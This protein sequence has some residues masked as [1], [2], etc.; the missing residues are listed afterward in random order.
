MEADKQDRFTLLA[1]GV[2]LAL[3]SCSAVWFFYSHRYLLYYGDA[4]AHL[5]IARRVVDSQT[6]GYLQLGSPWLPLPHVLM[7]PFV[8]NDWLW[9]SGLAGAIPSAACFT[10]AGLFLFAAARR[11]FRCTAAAAT[12]TAL[13]ALNPNLLYLQSIPMSESIFFACLMALLYFTVRF[14]QTQG[15]GAV[16]GAGAAACAATLS[17]YDGWVLL[18]FA[19]LFFLIAARG[20]RLQAALLFSAIAGLGPVYWIAH[21][22][23]LTGDPL[24]FYSGPYSAKAIQGDRPYAGKDNWRL[25]LLYVRTAAQLDVGMGLWIVGTL[26]IVAAIWRRAVWPLL[27]FTLTP[28]FYVWSMHSS[29]NPIHV[30]TLWPHSYYN[31]RYGMSMLPLLVLCAGALVTLAPRRARAMVAVLAIAAGSIHWLVDRGSGNWMTWEESRVNSEGRRAW[32]REAARFLKP[33]FVPGSGIVTSFGDITGIYREMGIPLRETFTECDGLPWDAAMRRPDLFLW[34]E[35]AVVR[36]GDTVWT[37]VTGKLAAQQFTLVKTII[38]KDE[39]VIE[40]Y[41]RGSGGKYG[42]S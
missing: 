23:Y 40:I 35:W 12:A 20:R 13:F 7:L 5:N 32:T 17:R 8:V 4:E 2:A 38:K 33:R 22:W 16:A 14:Q 6:P 31:T 29:G 3:L 25:A 28:L 18:P 36:R 41:R 42:S 21:N 11:I 10:I 26:G 30:P 39:P 34:Q 24:W 1:C 27:L 37:A 9:R 19:A 15:L